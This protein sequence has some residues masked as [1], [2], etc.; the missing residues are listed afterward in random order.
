MATTTG[1]KQEQD[2]EAFLTE[3][4]LLTPTSDGAEAGTRSDPF[5]VIR[6]PILGITKWVG[7]LVGGLGLTASAVLA[8]LGTW[9]GGLTSGEHIALISSAAA[10]LIVVAVCLT[11]IMVVDVKTRMALTLEKIAARADITDEYMRTRRV[12]DLYAPR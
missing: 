10:L 6:A 2:F 11:W 3:L 7:G 5:V 12:Q 9:L 4:H 8:S 1:T